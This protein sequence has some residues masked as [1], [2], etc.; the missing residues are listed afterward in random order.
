MAGIK[1]GKIAQN[2]Q[3]LLCQILMMFNLMILMYNATA[4]YDVIRVDSQYNCAPGFGNLA[5]KQNRE[6]TSS[7]NYLDHLR[8]KFSRKNKKDLGMVRHTPPLEKAKKQREMSL[9]ASVPSMHFM[10]SKSSQQEAKQEGFRA[11]LSYSTTQK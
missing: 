10:C 11:G 2:C 7:P 6:V 8:T 9:P 4:W 5:I 3:R 1:F